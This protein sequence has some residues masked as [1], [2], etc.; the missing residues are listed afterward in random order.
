MMKNAFPVILKAL[1]DLKISKFLSNW[2][3]ITIQVLPNISRNKGNQAITFGQ[4]I[5]YSKRTIFLQKSCRKSGKETSSRLFLKKQ[6]NFIKASAL[7]LS[8]NIFLQFSTWTYINS[9]LYK[10][11]TIDPEIQSILIFQKRV[12]E[13]FLNL[14]LSMIFREK[15]FSRYIILTDEISLSDCPYFLR[16]WAISVLQLLFSFQGHDVINIEINL[17]FLIKPF[18]NMT[19]K[20]RQKFK[21]LEN[22]KC[23]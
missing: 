17:I 11:Q 12:F 8:F 20:S 13:Q 9:K 23:F 2:L 5:K 16:Y 7:Q 4:F 15:C 19:K 10:I 18:F 1:F 3:T 14:I 22:K 6:K 21:Y